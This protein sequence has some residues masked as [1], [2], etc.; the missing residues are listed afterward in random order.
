[1][2]WCPMRPGRD[3]HALANRLRTRLSEVVGERLLDLYLFVSAATG[4]FKSGIS[5]I[6]TFAV[7]AADP[8]HDDI[9]ALARTHE[10]RWTIPPGLGLEGGRCGRL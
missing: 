9:A 2:I 5:D 4:A 10:S 6:D 7:L 3:I 1:M 8:R